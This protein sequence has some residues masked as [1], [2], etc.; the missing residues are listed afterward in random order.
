MEI[1]FS[2]LDAIALSLAF[3]HFGV[4]LGYYAYLKR[5]WLRKPWGIRSDPSYAPS[6]TIIVPTYNEAGLIEKKLDDISR[7]DYPKDRIEVL[8]IDSASSD[9]T[10]SIARRW[11]EEHPDLKISVIEEPSRRGKAYALNRALS[12]ASG[13][14]VVIT[15]ADSRWGTSDALRRAVSKFS[16]PSVGA[17]SCIKDPEA[18]GAAGVEEGYRGYYNVLRVAES[19][20]WSTPVFHGE[21]AAFRKDVL[22]KMGGFPTDIGADDSYTATRIALVGFRSIVAEDVKCIEAVPKKGYSMWR[23]RRAQHLLQHFSKTL[24]EEHKIPE[25]FKPILC[26]ETFLHLVNPWILLA[27]I[28]LLLASA[29]MG[30]ILAAMLLATGVALLLYKPYRTWIATQLYL[31]AA[32]VRN[33]RTKEIVWEKQEKS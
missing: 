5:T 15:D 7:Q 29:V 24:R 22:V 6:V 13:E 26:T 19:K 11:S 1:Q 27:A 30:S 32:A 9:G 10:A 14:I 25:K 3:I 20:A 2:V 31:M 4:P 28:V 23:I 16:D 18:P 12:Y 21:L 17:I 8:V 33:L